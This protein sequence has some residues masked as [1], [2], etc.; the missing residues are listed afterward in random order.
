MARGLIL[1]LPFIFSISFYYKEANNAHSSNP[2]FPSMVQRTLIVVLHQL[3]HISNTDNPVS[4]LSHHIR[5]NTTVT[6]RTYYTKMST[7]S[8][9]SNIG[10]TPKTHIHNHLDDSPESKV[11]SL[12][13]YKGSSSLIVAEN[14]NTTLPAELKPS[15]PTGRDISSAAEL[16]VLQRQA[17][18]AFATT[19]QK[20]SEVKH[21]RARHVDEEADRGEIEWRFPVW[22]LEGPSPLAADESVPVSPKTVET[23]TYEEFCALADSEPKKR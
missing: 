19:E 3:H 17:E 11:Q 13:N 10:N 22:H 14:P 18:L 12:R 4:L 8:T 7:M 5:S 23:L 6:D 20:A 2:L 1:V 9:M 15:L 16:K 21:S